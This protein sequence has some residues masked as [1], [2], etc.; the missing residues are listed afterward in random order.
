MASVDD[1]AGLSVPGRGRSNLIVFFLLVM[2]TLHCARAIFFT[3]SSWIDLKAYEAGT[4]PNPYQSRALMVPVLRWA[5][6]V[7]VLQRIAD[8]QDRV[9]PAHEPASPEKMICIGVGIVALLLSAYLLTRFRLR[10]T[11]SRWWLPWLIFLEILFTSY[12]ARSSQANWYPYDLLNLLFCTVAA[13]GIYYR[14][15]W[16]L[17]A[18]M[19]LATANRETTICW[20]VIWVFA[21]YK[22][23]RPTR[24]LVQAAVL[25]ALWALVFFPL[26][27]HY[28]AQPF[29]EQ[30]QRVMNLKYVL[31]PW[32]WPQLFS[33]V[34]FLP[35]LLVLY[36]RDL[37]PRHKRILLG[38]CLSAAPI[39]WRGLWTESRIFLDFVPLTVLICMEAL[40]HSGLFAAKPV[41]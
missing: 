35:V 29:E 36:C 24:T 27:L 11:S 6:H 13:I 28:S 2:G 14:V 30:A 9:A 15:W 12:A 17:A 23:Q 16:P 31:G 8:W 25:T 32:S 37:S 21:V 3:N 1:V 39:L 4:A 34:G 10:S 33:A 5:S 26:K 19:P 18:L 20:V 7:R 22:E 38:I 41:P 40:N